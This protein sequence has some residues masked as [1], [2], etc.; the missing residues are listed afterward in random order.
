MT[1][2]TGN[3]MTQD[4]YLLYLLS[5]I[6]MC[7]EDVDTL[8]L[9][10]II[11][12]DNETHYPLP[13]CPRWWCHIG[14]STPAN[15]MMLE[16]RWSWLPTIYSVFGHLMAWSVCHVLHCYCF[17]MDCRLNEWYDHVTTA[18][19]LNLQSNYSYVLFSA[20]SPRLHNSLSDLSN[21]LA[22]YTFIRLGA[23]SVLYAQYL[24]SECL[25]WIW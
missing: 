6:E 10:C 21:E 4:S 24:L 1:R 16:V 22:S 2:I 18:W 17:L 9:C 3:L 20:N 14:F 11:F 7:N 23:K 5:I 8:T 15:C 12:A 13:F 19:C 25:I